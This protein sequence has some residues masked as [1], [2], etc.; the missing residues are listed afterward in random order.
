MLT[1]CLPAYVLYFHLWFVL[2]S[3]FLWILKI[4]F[5]LKEKAILIMISLERSYTHDQLFGYVCLHIIFLSVK[6]E[7]NW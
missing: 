6:R 2:P 7:T 3:L 1:F 5:F 4:L